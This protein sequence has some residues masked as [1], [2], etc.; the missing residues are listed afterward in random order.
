M[1]QHLTPEWIKTLGEGYEQVYRDWLHRVANLTFTAYNSQYSNS[2]FQDKKTMLHGFANSGIR[3][4]MFIAKYD[5]W[6]LAELEARNEHLMKQALEIWCSPRKSY[7]PKEKELEQV[8]LDDDVDLTGKNIAS[9]E[10]K[11]TEQ[12]V[13]SWAEMF[14][15]VVRLLRS[16]DKS[17]N[18]YM[19]TSKG[20]FLKA[21]EI[22]PDIYM[23]GNTSTPE[24]LKMLRKLFKVYNVEPSEL[25]FYLKGE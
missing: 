4:N 1:P 9:F 3:M 24:K 5:K 10:Y 25:V 23:E 18:Q 6:T 12:P 22:E 16:E 19:S 2:S 14:K 15:L 17:M 13:K 7:E 21:I 20:N 11:N 8:S